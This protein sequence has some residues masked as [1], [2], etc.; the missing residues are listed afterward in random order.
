MALA[1]VFN[2]DMF[3]PFFGL[4]R[5]LARSGTADRQ[6][7]IAIDVVEKDKEFDIKADVP[8][9]D[10]NDIKLNVEGDVLTIGVQ[11][12]EKKEEEQEAEGGGKVHRSERSMTFATRAL[13]MPDNA[14]LE[15]VEAKYE[16]GVL[17]VK[18]P[19]TEEKERARQ[20]QVS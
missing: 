16:N 20:I 12:E 18:V 11:K 14:D 6:R 2:D 1:T 7:G 3:A 4:D 5:A 17:C 19:K 9:V 15:H 8:G 10:K 13:R